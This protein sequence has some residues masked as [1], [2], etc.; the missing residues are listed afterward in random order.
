[1]TNYLNQVAVP[2]HPRVSVPSKLGKNM[3]NERMA[4][5]KQACDTFA[6]EA[7][8]QL[9]DLAKVTQNLSIRTFTQL[10]SMSNFV[11]NWR[12]YYRHLKQDSTQSSVSSQNGTPSA[13]ATSPQEV[14]IGTEYSGYYDT[15]A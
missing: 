7:I 3:T 10:R 8:R 5:W 12:D 9:E 4:L 13:T 6:T 11:S 1:M 2:N 15:S 14:Q